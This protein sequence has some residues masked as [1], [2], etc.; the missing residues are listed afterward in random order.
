MAIPESST[1]LAT[2]H[3]STRDAR[4]VAGQL[5]T[6]PESGLSE[7]EAERR[8]AEYGPNELRAATRKPLWK[9]ALAQFADPLIILL[10]V[11]A[12]VSVAAWLLEGED[13][14]PID[15]IVIGAIIV[16]NSIIGLA[17]EARADRAVAALAS[18]TRAQSTVLRDGRIRSASSADLVPGDILLLAEGDRV[19]ADA[20]VLTSHSLHTMESSLTGESAPVEKDAA[21]LPALLPLGDRANMVFAGTAVTRGNARAIITA[22]GMSTETG[23]IA[24]LLAE[25]KAEATPLQREVSRLGRTLSIIVISIAIVVMITIT[26]V[27]GITSPADLVT[28]L[29]L[30]VSLAVAAVPEGLPALL[31]IVLALGVQ[32]MA[33]RNAIVKS[34]SS[35]ESL[36]SA[37]VIC[38]DKTGTLTT[39]RMRIERVVT[40]SGETDVSS[41]AFRDLDAE[42]GAT[43]AALREAEVTLR[44]GA[45]AND[46]RLVDEGGEIQVEGDPT[47]TAFL[48]A[49]HRLDSERPS[50]RRF[51]RIGEVP[52]S[53]ERKMMS[54]AH[55]EAGGP[56]FVFSKGAPDVLLARCTDQRIGDEIVPLDDDGRRR[57][58]EAV[59]TLSAQAYRTLGVAY[60][61]APEEVEATEGAAFDE[62]HEQD[63]VY[64]G[65]VGIIDP[66]RP[67]AARAI[68]E[69]HRAGIRVIMIT[70]DHP[71][72]AARIARDLGLASEADPVVSGAELES[73]DDARLRDIVAATPVF[74]R[75]APEHKLRIVDALQER[76]QIVA[77]TGDGVND[78]PALK[79]ADIGI[80][81]GIAGTEVT[82][83]AARMVLTDDNFATIVAA[84][85][86]GRVIFDNIRKFLR[87]LLSSNAGEVLTV[88]FGVVFAGVLGFTQASPEAVVLPLLATQILWTNLVT[89][90]APAL[91]MGVD[92]EVDDVMARPPR[93]AGDRAIDG[94][95]WAIIATTGLT[96]SIATLLTM[97]IFLP[98]GIVPGGVDT[99]ET[100]RTAGFTTLV[101]AALLTAFNARSARAS[102]VRGLLRNRVLWGSFAL[103]V[104]LQIA[105]VYV[106]FL[107]VAFGTTAL[108][109]IHWAV[110]IGLASLVIWVEEVRKAIVRARASR[111]DPDGIAAR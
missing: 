24:D 73:A 26:L 29:L 17:Q 93:G 74:A 3:P 89:D 70:G 13:P 100:A 88:F 68:E 80:A 48:L 15:A 55:R 18:L 5:G 56:V 33:K 43:G 111:L 51:G 78:A 59:E 66:P 95:M 110:S 9:R 52:F 32:R 85:R 101:L 50:P 97:D 1:P 94:A 35:V 27:Q 49:A 72:T 4:D 65:T 90:S 7:A 99:F 37:S 46:A 69:A 81:M 12:G 79:S 58:L 20:R 109:P 6:D 96:M 40:A 39:N 28:V 53:S 86:E 30:G 22:T 62:S 54:T 34:L 61:I 36:G 42:G 11:A 63:L 31:S 87:Y 57:A 84:V 23:A 60:R 71:A 76:G 47:E 92:P 8:L 38:T 77:M 16:L 10:L 83:E 67:E 82:K 108:E 91:A 105:V 104:V 44:V 19:G 14:V 25:T 41:T 21:I 103:A 102:V 98:G 75:V 64:V 106:P 2:G 45:L 107:Q